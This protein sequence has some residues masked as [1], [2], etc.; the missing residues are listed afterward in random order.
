MVWPF[1]RKPAPQPVEEKATVSEVQIRN[2]DGHDW[3]MGEWRAYAKE[4]FAQNPTIYRCIDLVSTN[5]ASVKPK[6]KVRGEY[7]YE[8]P[9]LELL[10]RPNPITGGQEF[11]IEAYAWAL[12]TGNIFTD[13]QILGG[14]V[15]EMYNWQPYQFSIDRSSTNTQLPLRYWAN[16]DAQGQR[17]WDVDPINGQSDMF[18]LALF[19][20]KPDA[21]FMGMAP[22]E[23]AATSGD[24]LN[25]AAKWRYNS[26]KNDCRPSLAIIAKN[27]NPQQIKEV[28]K[29]MKK[30]KSGFKN[31]GENLLL[32][33]DTEVKTISMNPKDAEWLAGTKLNKQEICE[34]FGCPT[35]LLGIEGSQT[36]ANYSEARYAFYIQT[37]LPLVDLYFDELNRWLQPIYGEDVVICYDKSDIDALDYERQAK[38]QMIL[39]SPDVTK[40]EKRELLGLEPYNDPEADMLFQDPNLLPL[41]YDAFTEEEAEAN[42][43][44]KA[45]RMMGMDKE[46]AQTKAMEELLHKKCNHG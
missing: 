46:A 45:Y 5:A 11:R 40:N 21:G 36:Y 26:L 30:E 34:V 22:L 41:G 23:A 2:P 15:T 7:V 33:G 16:K 38:I 39:D 6:V 10:R 32:G 3:S 19:N 35:Q 14:R 27:A 25:A 44:A 20:P 17:F 1:T 18:H 37:V 12:L 31:A 4:G 8:H 24:Q 29:R 42:Q 43:M 28:E 9:L 13:R